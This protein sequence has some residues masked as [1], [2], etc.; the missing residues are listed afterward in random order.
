MMNFKDLHRDEE[1]LLMANVWDVAS[2]KVAEKLNFQAVGTSSGAIA[3]MLGYDD[4]EHMSFHE[5][6]YMIARIMKNT[7]LPVSVD[8]EAGYGQNA[9]EI[10]ANIL[11]LSELGVIGCN[12]E[13]STVIGGQRRLMERT[14]FGKLLEEIT[15]VLRSAHNTIF[16]NIRTDT[17]LLG[18]NN[19]LEET[20]QRARHYQKAGADGLFV[21]C[22][23]KE[24]DIKEVADATDLPINVMCM[25][26]LPDVHTLKKLGVKRISMG[27]FTFNKMNEGLMGILEKIRSNQNFIS[28]F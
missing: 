21:P 23:E 3:A 25:P 4:G 6:R 14:D 24:V 28:L 26:N 7:E 22:I 1:P 13:D 2:T 17:F 20:K 9:D 5:M 15:S 16:I 11:E 27:N 18:L 19:A 8:L 10:V 12:I